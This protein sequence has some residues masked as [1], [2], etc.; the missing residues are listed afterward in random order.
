MAALTK[1]RQ[2]PERSGK[3]FGFPVKADTRIFAGAIV[4]LASG[5][6]EPGKT[7]TG[8]VAVGRAEAHADSQGTGLARDDQCRVGGGR[9]LVLEKRVHA[10]RQ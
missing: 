9:A 8:L 4:V 1:D 7:A 2:T 6:A 5:L 3:E 10:A